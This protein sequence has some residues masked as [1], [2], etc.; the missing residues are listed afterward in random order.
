M[1]TQ[2]TIHE[3][4]TPAD[5]YEALVRAFPEHENGGTRW[6]TVKAD[7]V[8]LTFYGSDKPSAEALNDELDAQH[9]DDPNEGIDAPVGPLNPEQ[10]RALSE[11]PW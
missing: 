2:V 11:S 8:T 9:E 4:N 10:E 5:L 6:V 1:S 3:H 7:N